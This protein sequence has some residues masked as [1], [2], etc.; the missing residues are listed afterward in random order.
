MI[1]IEFDSSAHWR[2]GRFRSTFGKRPY[3]RYWW[4]W[5]AVTFWAGNQ[6]E[7]GEAAKNAAWV[8]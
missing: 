4:L 1:I 2:P 6:H 8:E 5:F 7:F 3:R